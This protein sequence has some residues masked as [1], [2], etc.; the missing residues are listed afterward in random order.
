MM[1]F[2]RLEPPAW[3]TRS[4]LEDL[5]GLGIEVSDDD[6]LSDPVDGGLARYEQK[7]ADAIALGEAE[8]FVWIR[9][10]RDLLY[11][12]KLPLMEALFDAERL[13]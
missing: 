11:L 6:V 2:A 12:H 8:G 10:D 3:R 5:L 1:T 9:V 4:R 13:G 7:L